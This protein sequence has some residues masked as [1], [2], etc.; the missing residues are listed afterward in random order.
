MTVHSMRMPVSFGKRAKKSK[1]R[2]LSVMAHL[3]RSVVAVKAED[4]CMSHALIIAIAKAENDPENV[5]YRRGYK[6][7][8]VVQKCTLR[9]VSTCPDVGGFPN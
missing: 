3:K 9:Q 2:P 8:P 1:G 7:L 6:I 4:N 5:A